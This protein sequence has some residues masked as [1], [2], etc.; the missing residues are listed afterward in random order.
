M[1]NH[2]HFVSQINN[3]INILKW[4]GYN[5]LFH[6]VWWAFSVIA[7]IQIV[8]C[9]LNSHLFKFQQL[10]LLTHGSCRP[11]PLRPYSKAKN[12]KL[13]KF[14]QLTVCLLYF[15]PTQ[16]F[17]STLI[18]LIT[19]I[20]TWI[21]LYTTFHYD[22]DKTT[23]LLLNITK[24]RSWNGNNSYL[25][26]QHLGREPVVTSYKYLRHLRHILRCN[27]SP[28]IIC[29]SIVHHLWINGSSIVHR[30][31]INSS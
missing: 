15:F 25:T 30:W 31:F 20:T 27:N 23:W 10:V 4:V 8:F 17:H 29:E 1:K 18:P 16:Q 13:G 14:K 28:F 22:L 7:N 9:I 19:M 21:T 3:G 12:T 11:L 2:I 26:R 5:W 24:K 6:I